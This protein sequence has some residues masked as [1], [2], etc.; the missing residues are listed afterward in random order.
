MGHTGKP[1]VIAEIGFN[2]EGDMDLAV[3]MIRAAAKA[4]ASAV[5]FQTY[6]AL[7]LALPSS[8]H[9]KA[10]RCGE[11]SLDQHLRLSETAKKSK[12]DFISTPYSQWAV[13]LL[14]KIGVKAYKIASMDLTNTEL[15]KYVADTGRPVYVSTGMANLKEIAST[16]ST[17]RRFKSGPI[18]MLHCLSKYPADPGDINLA[19]MYEIRKICKCS[20][21]YSD[22]AKGTFACLIA[23]ILGAEV[24][25]KHFTLDTSKPGADHYHSADEAQFRKMV[26][27]IHT[28]L[29]IIGDPK[30]I[31][32]RVD[33]KDA[34]LYRRG[35]YA[36]MGIP[37]GASITREMLVCCRP[38]SEF[39]PSDL[40]NIIDRTAR[41][42]IK[43]NSPLTANNI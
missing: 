18:T 26:D 6:R 15:L 34:A 8:P 30:V 28:A 3:K 22:H 13:D 35:I 5:K 31:A 11:M 43:A 38:A 14:E 9:F 32:K 19:F 23:A 25:E 40:D 16:V 29:S 4:G 17:L 10:I 24:I 2:H 42:N 7:D 21:G 27:D 41:V 12:V 1:Y 39:G 33:R 37:K 20:V 36:R